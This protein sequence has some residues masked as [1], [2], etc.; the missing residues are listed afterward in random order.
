MGEL[1]YFINKT[2]LYKPEDV[3]PS[4][5]FGLGDAVLQTS[6][7]LYKNFTK[8]WQIS[9]G[10][11]I[12]LP[13]GVFDQELNYVKLPITVQPS[14]GSFKYSANIFYLNTKHDK[15]KY[16]SLGL[17][18]LAA[19][20]DSKNF[21]YQYGNIYSLAFGS[22][23]QISKIISTNLMLRG[24]LRTR[25][26]REPDIIVESSGGKFIYLSPGINIKLAPLLHLNSSIN[27]PVYKY[28][29]GIQLANSF[30]INISI[31]KSISFEH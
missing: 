9:I 21:K 4:E 24:E 28:Y 18:E 7:L 20:I 16:Y 27:I 31:H 26:E 19:R 10:A 6:Y 5:G 23:Y 1:G 15:I 3:T 25:S 2:E 14:S 29:N 17:I 12:K 11:G 30:I 22:N 13:I 8:K